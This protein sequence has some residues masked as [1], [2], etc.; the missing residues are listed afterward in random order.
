MVLPLSGHNAVVLWDTKLAGKDVGHG[1]SASF[2]YNAV[3]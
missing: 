2:L 3:S 1:K